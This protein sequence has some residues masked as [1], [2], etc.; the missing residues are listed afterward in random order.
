MPLK[1]I[2][3]RINPELLYVLAK[4]GHGDAI[5]IADSNFPSD[6]IASNCI[7]KQPIRVSGS[8]SEVLHDILQLFPLDQYLEKPVKVM[9]RV[10]SDKEKGLVVPAY[11][12]LSKAAGFSSVDKLDYIERF[13]FYE[14]AKKC[15]AVIQT[16]DS[17]LYAN[18]IIF[19]GVL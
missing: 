13:Q 5:I 10:K 1:G 8:T 17:S 18:T 19:K 9:D 4:L 15:Y 2:P 16:D 14:D 11:V 6:S 12:A 3:L 7:V